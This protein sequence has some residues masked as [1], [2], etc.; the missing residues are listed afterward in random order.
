M[1]DAQYLK[2][3]CA[4]KQVSLR[5]LAQLLDIDEATLHR[6]IAGTSDFYRHEISKIKEILQL[7]VADMNRIFFSEKLA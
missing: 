7:S 3:C 6:K 5:Q 4:D 2:K 1:V